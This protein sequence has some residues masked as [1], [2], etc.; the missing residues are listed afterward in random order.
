MVSARGGG[1]EIRCYDLDDDALALGRNI[2]K[3]AG[4]AES[5]RFEARDI[6]KLR[7]SLRSRADIVLAI[8]I[9]CGLP[10]RE[11]VRYL[12]I[13]RRYLKPGGRLVASNVSVNM[14][15]D[16][17]FNAWLLLNITGWQLVYKTEEEL[18]AIFEEAGFEW[19]GAYYD[20]PT[21]FHAMGIGRV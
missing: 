16:D 3:Q 19:E 8:G 1:V 21:R 7:S 15:R 20:E 18:R 9:L 17:V 13:F 11:C 12:R 10:H 2:A 4:V 14:L 5:V 6:L